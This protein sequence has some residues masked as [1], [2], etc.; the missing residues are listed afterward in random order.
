MKVLKYLEKKKNRKW[1]VLR[2]EVRKKIAKTRQRRKG[3]F[4]KEEEVSP[5]EINIEIAV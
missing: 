3:R 2:Y 5:P 1:D 4:I